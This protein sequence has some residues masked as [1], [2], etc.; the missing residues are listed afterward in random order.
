MDFATIQ[1]VAVGGA[2]ALVLSMIAN[3]LQWKERRALLEQLIATLNMQNETAS[4]MQERMLNALHHVATASEKVAESQEK[5]AASQAAVTEAVH[6]L[7]MMLKHGSKL[8]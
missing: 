2:S 4:K 8:S 5:V 7:S 6:E 3:V 1:Q